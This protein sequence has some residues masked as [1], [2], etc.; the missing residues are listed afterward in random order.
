MGID[1]FDGTIA[2][3]VISRLAGGE[4][5]E[6]YSS[7]PKIIQNLLEYSLNLIENFQIFKNFDTTNL[8][9]EKPSSINIDYQTAKVFLVEIKEE[10]IYVVVFFSSA[11]P[12]GLLRLFLDEYI[13]YVKQSYGSL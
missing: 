2:S 3:F 4:I 5:L 13:N 8:Q 7:D 12:M 10:D 6:S 1:K 9:L 11:Y